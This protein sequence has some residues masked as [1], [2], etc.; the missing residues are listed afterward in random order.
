MNL[1]EIYEK[2]EGISLE[3]FNK[4]VAEKIELMGGLCD[5]ITA[6]L[7][8]AHDLGYDNTVKIAEIT[9][10]KRRISFSGYVRNIFEGREFNRED[11]SI[12]RVVNIIMQDETGSIKVALWDEYADRVKTG[13]LK[14]G[15]RIRV[16]GYV[17]KSNL[18]I[19]VSVGRNGS[20]D[21]LE[22]NQQM[23]GEKLK[24]AQIK[25]GMAAV[26]LTA[27][28]LEIAPVKT[29]QRRDGKEGRV[30]GLILGDETGKAYLTLWNEQAAEAANLKV[31]DV[32]EIKNAYSKE[33]YGRIELHLGRG[34]EV[35]KVSVDVKYNENITLLSEIEANKSFNV[36]GEIVNI[37]LPREFTRSDGSKGRVWNI[38]IKDESGEAL[39]AAL[40]GE[41]IDEF[42][43]L[44]PRVGSKIKILDC[45]AKIGINGEIELSVGKRSKILI[46]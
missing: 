5:E 22:L 29:F 27:K 12:G 20:L 7:L 44:K 10:E 16:S 28:V 25:P 40:W 13:E 32:I 2:L 31:G 15:S 38:K 36:Q 3:E 42:L 34:G 14:V 33:K 30:A 43:K 41:Q 24:I 11:G 1:L 23:Q 46:I 21:V 17:K 8:V 35:Q 6:A 39:R 4:R 18:G 9:C 45:Y 37:E 19:E 26:N